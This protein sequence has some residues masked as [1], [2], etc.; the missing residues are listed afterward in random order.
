MN[1]VPHWFEGLLTVAREHD[2]EDDVL[3]GGCNS[4]G[5]ADAAAL[6]QAFGEGFD[7]R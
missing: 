3:T 5:R 7:E 1:T 6:A 2:D 4:A